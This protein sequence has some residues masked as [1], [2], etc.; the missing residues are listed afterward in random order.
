MET[1]LQGLPGACVYL[2]DILI[3]GK[4]NEEHLVNL[5][6]VLCRLATAGMKLKSHKCSSL[7]GSRVFGSQD[8]GKWTLAYHREGASHCSSTTTYQFD[9][10]EVTSE[11]D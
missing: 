2:D 7:A 4:S 5:S 11:N 3:S 8:F 10:A 1:I 6:A 9:P